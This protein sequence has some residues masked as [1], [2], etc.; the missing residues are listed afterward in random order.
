MNTLNEIINQPNTVIVDVRTPGEF[1]AGHVE[2]SM[3]IPL[4]KVPDA[5][6]KFRSMKAP[7]VLCCRSGQRSG[8]ALTWLKQQ[9]LENVYNGG[10]YTD[11]L[12]HKA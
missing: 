8:Q 12:I 9:G 7:I 6:E 5:L 3:N 2:G 1:E 10:G 4:D 11:V